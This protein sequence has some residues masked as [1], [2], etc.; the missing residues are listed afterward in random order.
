MRSRMF[1]LF[2]ENRKSLP[3]FLW[4]KKT[5][6]K[7]NP[8]DFKFYLGQLKNKHFLRVAKCYFWVCF[9]CNVYKQYKKAKKI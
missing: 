5:F 1:P 7:C 9:H 8:P 3:L 4:G 2:L 6:Q